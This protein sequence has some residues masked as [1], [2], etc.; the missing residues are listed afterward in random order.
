MTGNR[1]YSRDTQTTGELPVPSSRRWWRKPDKDEVGGSS[2]PRPTQVT[3]LWGLQKG[4]SPMPVAGGSRRGGQDGVGQGSLPF[5][6]PGQRVI[7]PE[8]SSH[9]LGG[10]GQ[11]PALVFTQPQKRPGQPPGRASGPQTAL[12]RAPPGP[13]EASAALPP[14]ASAWR[15]VRRPPRHPGSA[16]PS[17][18]LT[19]PR[20]TQRRQT[21]PAYA[22]SA[23]AAVSPPPSG[24][25]MVLR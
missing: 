24:Y 17:R 2:P 16:G 25:C 7:R 1:A 10:P 6:R 5:V 18:S 8:P 3:A 11:R 15:A 19:P 20:S 14:A 22:G 12:H 4:V 13:F 21:A 23:P 9:Q